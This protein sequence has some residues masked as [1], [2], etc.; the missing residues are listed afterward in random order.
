M[1]NI[2]RNIAEEIAKERNLFLINF[3]KRGSNSKPIF[4]IFIDNKGGITTDI[5][6]EF[7]KEIKTQIEK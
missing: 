5:C 4:E 2:V 7:S 3:I 1:K 6:A